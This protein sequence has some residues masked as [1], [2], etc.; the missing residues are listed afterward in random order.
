VRD[1]ACITSRQDRPPANR[2]LAVWSVAQAIGSAL[3]MLANPDAR[4]AIR[5]NGQVTHIPFCRNH[6]GKTA[7]FSSFRPSFGVN[8]HRFNVRWQS[9]LDGDPSHPHVATFACGKVQG[10]W[11]PG[12]RS[13]VNYTYAPRVIGFTQRKTVAGGAGLI[14]ESCT[15]IAKSEA[16]LDDE[17]IDALGTQAFMETEDILGESRPSKST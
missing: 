16:Q 15:V 14:I 9:L 1:V 11:C 4:G 6:I 13:P 7:E 8:A 12:H 17:P 3:P 5:R 10:I 2:L